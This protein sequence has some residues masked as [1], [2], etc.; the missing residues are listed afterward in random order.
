MDDVAKKSLVIAQAGFGIG[1]VAGSIMG[2]PNFPSANFAGFITAIACLLLGMMLAYKPSDAHN[3]V[4]LFLNMFPTAA[5]AAMILWYIIIL[6][7]NKEYIEENAMPEQWSMNAW[8]ISIALLLHVV[9]INVGGMYAALSWQTMSV[10]VIFVAMQ[11]VVAE[12]FRTDG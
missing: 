8:F 1:A 12:N 7:N 10:I 9:I 3:M 2:L 4:K 6:Q 11:H 5:V